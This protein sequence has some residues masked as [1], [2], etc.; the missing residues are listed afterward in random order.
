[1]TESN[2]IEI[3]TH[4]PK[5]TGRFLS[6][7]DFNLVYKLQE[8][9]CRELVNSKNVVVLG[10]EHS[11]VITLGRRADL[12]E[13]FQNDQLPVVRST[14]GGLA[15]IHSRGQLVIYPILNLHEH[16][17]S[18]KRYVSL[19]LET[20]VELLEFY[21]VKSWIDLKQVGAY[22]AQGKI[23]FCGIEIKNRV[24]LHGISLNISNNLDLFKLISPCGLQN[25]KM[26]RLQ[27]HTDSE[28]DLQALFS[29]WSSLFQEK[30]NI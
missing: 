22:T 27:N 8:Q 18:V 2:F 9:V 17:L 28:L 30:L 5:F 11:D 7:T 12:S 4:R 19:L 20:S 10:C 29:Q 6:I 15:T 26:D 1:M 25:S 14:R 23:A 21:G 24:S 13:V 3:I 16:G